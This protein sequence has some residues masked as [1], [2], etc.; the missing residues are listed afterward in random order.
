MLWYAHQCSHPSF[1]LWWLTQ[2]LWGQKKEW[3]IDTVNLE[4]KKVTMHVSSDELA[5]HAEKSGTNEIYDPFSFM[6][7]DDT[8]SDIK[9]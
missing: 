9:K 8:V 1:K 3:I 7:D 4:M 6:E 2:A 5:E